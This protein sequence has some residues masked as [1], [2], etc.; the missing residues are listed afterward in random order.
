[1]NFHEFALQENQ[2]KMALLEFM[3]NYHPNDSDTLNMIS[4]CF[5]MYRE[6]AQH[7]EQRGHSEITRIKTRLT[8]KFTTI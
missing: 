5:G 1:M 2:L 6:A 8:S 4:V 7:L 3:K